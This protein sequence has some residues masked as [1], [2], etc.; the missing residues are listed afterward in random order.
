MYTNLSSLTNHG[1]WPSRIADHPQCTGGNLRSFIAG[2]SPM[3]RYV[4]LMEK[5]KHL[6][7][8]KSQQSR[9]LTAQAMIGTDAA[10][11]ESPKASIHDA[12]LAFFGL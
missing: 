9:I 7:Q 11:G 2:K 8:Q 1:P 6:W 3:S 10:G 12:E 5:T 4:F